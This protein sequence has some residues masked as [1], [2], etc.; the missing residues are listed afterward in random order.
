MLCE[1]VSRSPPERSYLGLNPS[2]Q[3]PSGQ[4]GRSESTERHRHE[5]DDIGPVPCAVL[6]ISDS[7]T[8]KTDRSG[9]VATELIKAG[10][11]T[12]VHNGLVPNK[13]R[14]I[15]T[16]IH[17]AIKTGARFVFCTGG[18]G[19]GVHDIT[20]DT[21]TPMMDKVL[22][23]YGE[24]FRRASWDQIGAAAILSRAVAGR[25]GNSLVVCGPGSPAAVELALGDLL[26]PELRHF[27]R[28]VSR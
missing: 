11:H 16:E 3:T 10:G 12:I 6:V 27:I 7:R 22:E 4:H 26:V 21:V 24:W 20:V 25:L 1:L 9:R 18:T 2:D 19:L 14:I 15:Q 23:G 17:T 5:A 8:E 13:A 28:E